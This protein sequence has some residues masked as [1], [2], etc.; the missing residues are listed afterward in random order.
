VGTLS[1]EVAVRESQLWWMT[2]LTQR[3]RNAWYDVGLHRLLTK[4]L[5]KGVPSKGGCSKAPLM[6]YALSADFQASRDRICCRLG[7]FRLVPKAPKPNRGQGQGQSQRHCIWPD[8]PV[9]Q[10]PSWGLVSSAMNSPIMNR[11]KQC[12]RV[13]A[14]YD[15]LAANYLAFV[16]QKSPGQCRGRSVEQSGF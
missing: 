1:S 9:I 4:C 7:N 5:E 13:A 2:G 16:Q 8:A 10:T 12:R 11:I 3:R 6:R 15:R 14:R